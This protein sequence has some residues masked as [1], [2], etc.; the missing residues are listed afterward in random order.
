MRSK[1]IICLGTALKLEGA[2]DEKRFE[3][4]IE[5]LV[6]RHEAFRTS[7]DFVQNEPVQ[8]IETNISVDIEKIE[9]NGRDIQELMNDFIRPF[10][11]GKA[12][13]LR[14]GLVSV[15]VNV[16]YLLIDMHHIISDGASVGIL[17]EEL[18]ALYRGDKLQEL[19]VQYK[20]Y[21]VWSKSETFVAQKRA[22][23]AFWLEQLQ[24][25]SPVLGLPEDLP[26]PKVQ[27]FAGDRVSFTINGPLKAKLDEL[28][29]A[30]NSTTYTVLL[31]CYSTLLSKLSR[32]EDIIIGS[33]IV[34]RTHPD[35][36]SVIGM[37][38]NTLALRTKPAG[39]QTVA[40]FA[41][42]VH[43]L[44][45]EANKHQ[46][47]PFEELVDQVQTVRDTSRH[48]IFDVVFSME[49][50]DIRDLT[51]DGLYIV[52]EPFEE[53]IAKF[54]LTLTGNESADHIE[55][56]FDFNTSIFQQSSIEKWKE[57]FLHLLEQMVSAPDQSLDQMRLLS[58]KQRQKK[59]L[60]EW[61][62]PVLDVPSDQTVHALI[63]A[64]VHEA[65]LQKAAT[66]CGTSWTYEEL[67][68]RANVV[69][70]RLISSG[71]KPGDRVGILTRPS[72]D[73]TAAVL[74][75]LKTGA[76]F[77]PIDADYPDQRIAY[78]MEDCGAEILLMQKGLTAPTSFAGHVLLIED[79]VEG[80]AKEIQVHMKPTDLAYMIYTSG[81]TGQPKG[82]M[83]EH[84]SLVNLAFW[85]NDA[86][87]VTNADRTAKYA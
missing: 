76:A 58:P 82:V 18:S 3:K 80:E 33:P 78:M 15:S 7:F 56:V 6:H 84:Q 1:A 41:S 32:Q 49:N 87:Q 25:E 75:V 30:L 52:P 38:V 44:V 74:G 73:M 47:Y 17:I 85:H 45:L 62:G 12:P 31:T 40:E 68:S 42:N 46:L 35:I 70:S 65:P 67:N 39:H 21:A 54:D 11:V 61:S 16:H 69:A 23:E 28:V 24:G 71:T 55:L 66:F 79:A 14:V 29:R 72:L 10:D 13:L 4:V 43:Q 51:M 57:F 48:P 63:E 22:E 2:F 9:G 27:T 5:Q 34:G 19:P 8:R 36:Q 50:A 37:F 20:D 86:F 77:V 26:R 59:L 64:K 60:S 83:V 53:N 81:T